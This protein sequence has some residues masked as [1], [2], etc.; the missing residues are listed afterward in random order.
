MKKAIVLAAGEGTRM[1]SNT[2]K[3]L[4]KVL[5][6]TMLGNV[7]R[8]LKKSDIEKIIVI[9]GHG[10]DQVIKEIE[11]LGEDVIYK[12]QPIGEDAPY[13]TG[14]AVMAA[15]DEI[16]EDDEVLIVCGDTPLL[17][18]ETLKSFME[19]NRKNNFLASVMTADIEDNY[20]YGR[21]VKNSKGFVEKI[22]EE[23]DATELERKI[24]EINSGV[25]TFKGSALIDNLKKLD[26]DNSQ[27]ELYLTDVV[28]ILN[29]QEKEV[30]GFLISDEDEILGVNSRL[31]LIKCEKILQKRINESHLINGVTII[32]PENTTIGIDV[33]IE[34][35]TIIYPNAII[36][37]ET[38]IGKDCTIQGDTFIVDSTIEDGTCIKSS[39]IEESYVGKNVTIGPFAHLRPDSNVKE[40]AHIGNFVELK[41]TEFGENSKAGH[42]AYIGDSKVGRDVNIGCGVITVNYDGKDKFK[43]TIEDY[44]F[45]GSNSNLVAPVKIGKNSYVAAG[46]TITKDVNEEDL[47]IER[48]EQKS[49]AGW[50]RRKNKVK[51]TGGCE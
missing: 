44:A 50:V 39:Y 2:P 1:K 8:E 14:F 35:D 48:C 27:G 51:Q 16:S 40:N 45:V 26:T 30:G 7:I 32:N 20:G 17:K 6:I 24:T 36:T 38:K 5:G 29:S 21:I 33:E 47:A 13:G 43:T 46:S 4:H 18:G 34:Q 12:E 15:I 31:Q 11:T 9:V 23:K 41:N 19:Y 25:Y 49:I 10:K 37:G 42:L 3:V 28:R 22:V